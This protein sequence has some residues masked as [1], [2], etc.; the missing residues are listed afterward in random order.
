[1]AE[2]QELRGYMGW[3]SCVNSGWPHWIQHLAGCPWSS[4][5]SCQAEQLSHSRAS[6]QDAPVPHRTKKLTMSLLNLL[7]FLRKQFIWGSEGKAAT[8][9][10]GF[11][12]SNSCRIG[13][14]FEIG[15]GCVH[16]AE[17]WL[18]CRKDCSGVSL[19]PWGA[20]GPGS[21]C[22]HPAGCSPLSGGCWVPPSASNRGEITQGSFLLVQKGWKDV[23]LP[24]FSGERINPSHTPTHH[25]EQE[26]CGQRRS[27]TRSTHF[28]EL[29]GRDGFQR[30][31]AL[32]SPR[33]ALQ[34]GAGGL[35][36]PKIAP[37]RAAPP[38][39]C[40]PPPVCPDSSSSHQWRLL[41]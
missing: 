22:W 24:W 36:V 37:G 20:V 35:Q 39:S 18:W 28:L 41:S 40:G 32:L 8:A 7:T 21:V 19:P 27:R 13:L 17:G 33:L 34:T 16:K 15:T 2:A 25:H 14:I 30:P 3:A 26:L 31:V 12:H 6:L 29:M 23:V 38:A 4:A 1:M 9:D 10:N 5:R 11:A